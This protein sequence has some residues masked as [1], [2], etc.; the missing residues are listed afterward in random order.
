MTGEIVSLEARK[1]TGHL[2]QSW[3]A[4]LLFTDA[5]WIITR[6]C[7][8]TPVHHYTRN[9]KYEMAH[10]NL[11]IFNTKE[12]FNAFIDF[13]E[14]GRFKM[15]YINL[16]TPA[17]LQNNII[18]WIDLYLDIIRTPS[19]CAELVDQDEFNEAKA[20]GMLSKILADEA[21]KVAAG[22]MEVVDQNN[23][24]FLAMDYA[25]VVT[26]LTERF[27]LKSESLKIL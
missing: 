13:F 14:D 6:A 1:P 23:F 16:A 21:E 4:E 2:H 26:I 18:S 7:F 11:G 20:K 10:S 5:D 19:K 17:R 24:P 25:R 15:L 9:I 22:L 3:N 12:Y 8:G 27:D